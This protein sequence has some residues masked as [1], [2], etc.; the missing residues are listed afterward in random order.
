MLITTTYFYAPPNKFNIEKVVLSAEEAHHLGDVLR[1]KPGDEFFV[2]DGIGGL[3]KCH[4]D[5]IR[6]SGEIVASVL[7]EENALPKP[8]I[9]ICLALA[10]VRRKSLEIAVDWAVQLGISEFAPIVTDFVNYAPHINEKDLIR[11][12]NI[13][14]KAMKQS[15]RAWLPNIRETTELRDFLKRYGSSYNGILFADHDGVPAMPKRM[16]VPDA[17]ICVFI[18]PEGGFSVAEK[19]EFAEYGAVPFALGDARLRTETAAIAAITKVLAW[20]GN[21]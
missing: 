13:A 9:S 10:V 21:L 7:S 19:A 18:G 20:S 5:K 17:N 4:F 2:I 16:T 3:F 1:A 14:I 11:L 15:K 12:K 8:S 6:S